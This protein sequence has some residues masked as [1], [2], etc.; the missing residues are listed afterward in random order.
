MSEELTNK[1]AQIG[2]SDFEVKPGE[3]DISMLHVLDHFICSVDHALSL[4]DEQ[5]KDLIFET[6]LDVL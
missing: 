1:L 6:L 4:P 5:L 3:D 2:Y